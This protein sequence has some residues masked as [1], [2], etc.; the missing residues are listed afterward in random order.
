MALASL[1]ATSFIA[2]FIRHQ[3]LSAV[4]ILNLMVSLVLYYLFF[5]A[6]YYYVPKVKVPV[7]RALLAAMITS[8][9]FVIGKELLGLYLGKMAIASIYGAAGSLVV[10]L[11]WVYYSSLI[12]F[13]GA[14]MTLIYTEKRA[15]R[16]ISP[17][18]EI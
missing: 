12:V 6:T 16:S 14:Q 18:P 7:R 17:A 13:A 3:A 15:R 4:G 5:A 9:L 2:H 8:I 1:I 11:V 10:L